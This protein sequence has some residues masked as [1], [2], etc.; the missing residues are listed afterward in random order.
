MIHQTSIQRYE[1]DY[2]DMTL[3]T[4]GE[5]VK[6]VD[7]CELVD[8]LEA[9]KREAVLQSLASLGQA[10]DAYLAQLDAEK[11]RD[12]AAD[13]AMLLRSILRTALNSLSGDEPEWAI[14]ARVALKGA[15][16]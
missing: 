14:R 16:Q 10:E 11:Q 4:D 13:E 8:S 3:V 7:H 15:E 6:F 2:D 12:L 5:W 9:T 1:Q